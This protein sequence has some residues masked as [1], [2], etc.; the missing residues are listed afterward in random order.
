MSCDL[1]SLLD[2]LLYV[3][4]MLTVEY[5]KIKIKRRNSEIRAGESQ[6]R[7]SPAQILLYIR[8]RIMPVAPFAGN[9]AAILG[10]VEG[11]GLDHIQ[12]SL[13]L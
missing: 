2:G 10:A 5:P 3:A 11:G 8:K 6:Q 4:I 13:W 7:N 1:H 12:D 9:A